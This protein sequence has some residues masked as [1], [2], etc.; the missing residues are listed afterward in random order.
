MSIKRIIGSKLYPVVSMLTFHKP[1][2]LSINETLNELKNGK[3]LTRFGDGELLA[4]SNQLKDSF[5]D[6]DRHLIIELKK[7]FTST[8][9][10]LMVAIADT[11][12][13]GNMKD[14]NKEDQLFWRA[15]LVKHWFKLLSIIST[16]TVY[17]DAF[18][19]RPY[20]IFSKNI[21]RENIEKVFNCFK[22]LWHGKKVLIIEGKYSRFGVG[23]D[24]LSGCNEVY[25]IIGPARNAYNQIDRL[26]KNI[27]KYVKTLKPQII[28]ISL[29]QTATVLTWRL[30]DLNIQVIDIGHLDVEYNWYLEKATTKTS[31]PGKWVNEASKP[32]IEF[33]DER[34]L[35]KYKSE[36]INIVD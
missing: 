3:S 29:G 28:L 27:R 12:A 15:F 16:R 17:Y 2:V 6:N 14:I 10:K 30:R 36:I 8:D 31:V 18:V 11:F 21:S 23:D 5:Q 34:K 35:E 9:P 26:E 20:F 13:F 25:R 1:K 22:D 24:L 7:V 4:M 32:F 19:T 33:E